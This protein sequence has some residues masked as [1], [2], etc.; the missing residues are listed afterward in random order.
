MTE[1]DIDVDNSHQAL[2]NAINPKNQNAQVPVK[3]H[4]YDAYL[5]LYNTSLEVRYSGFLEPERRLKYL[6]RK[7]NICF[8]ALKSIDSYMKSQGYKSLIPIQKE[9]DFKE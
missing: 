5:S 9:F 7:F 6:K 2:R 3:K 4:C 1:R 8:E